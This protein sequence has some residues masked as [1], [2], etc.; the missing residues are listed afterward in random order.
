MIIFM[1]D[2]KN[3]FSISV[4]E[5]ASLMKRLP[6]GA[7]IGSPLLQICT[8]VLFLRQRRRTFFC[9]CIKGGACRRRIGRL[10]FWRGGR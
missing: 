5:A 3:C 2:H 1:K 7:L 4:N 6:G 8:D 10:F 9:G